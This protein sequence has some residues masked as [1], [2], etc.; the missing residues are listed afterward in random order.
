MF[1]SVSF[2]ILYG[3][4]LISWFPLNLNYFNDIKLPKFYGSYLILLSYMINC[5]KCGSSQSYGI[6]TFKLLR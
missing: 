4:I 3:I 5:F 1:K 6:T 2:T